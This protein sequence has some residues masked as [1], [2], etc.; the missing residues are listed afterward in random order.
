MLII[1]GVIL[2]LAGL[3]VTFFQKIPILGKLPG[4]IYFEKGNFRFY[5]PLMTSILLSLILTLISSLISRL[6]R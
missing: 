2:V 4:D 3:A 1:M 6:F 5:F